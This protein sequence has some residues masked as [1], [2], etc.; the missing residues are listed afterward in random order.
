MVRNDLVA[1]REGHR[2]R[3]LP[4]LGALATVSC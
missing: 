4:S 1:A 3:V 2:F